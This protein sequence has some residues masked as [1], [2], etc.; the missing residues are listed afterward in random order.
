MAAPRITAEFVRDLVMRGMHDL[1]PL[2]DVVTKTLEAT[3]RESATSGEIERLVS[4]DAALAAKILRVVNSAYYGLSGEVVSLS[5]AV[6]VL[7]MQQIRNLVLSVSV[8]GL[9]KSKTPE[10]Q[11]AQQKLWMHSFASAACAQ[12][13]SR[14]FKFGPRDA[15]AAYTAGLLHEIGKLYL[16]SALT[17]M[18]IV[19]CE[20]AAQTGIALGVREREEFGLGHD[21]IGGMLADRWHFPQT[22][23]DLIAR[24]EGPFEPGT[25]PLLLAVHASDR[26]TAPPY[27]G[28]SRA[29]LMDPVAEAWLN[30]VPGA[31]ETVVVEMEA[32]IAEAS[33]LYGVLLQ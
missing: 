26:L 1:P 18:Y 23:R 29:A 8:L 33:E 4:T 7:G 22:L 30:S 16:F 15:E 9:L 12:A 27:D 24:H 28:E 20:E 2:S 21:E 32:K 31:R 3:E 11:A 5:Q 19:F 25:D 6:V 14:V 17:D 10:M 13:I